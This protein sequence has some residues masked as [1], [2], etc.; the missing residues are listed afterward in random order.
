[1]AQIV[2]QW[3]QNTNRTPL[4]V[5]DPMVSDPTAMLITGAPIVACQGLTV[6]TKITRGQVMATIRHELDILE[7]HQNLNLIAV[8]EFI[9]CTE[10]NNPMKQ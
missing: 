4:I 6:I 9:Q 2:V 3:A 1:M 7:L 10:F 5:A 8:Q